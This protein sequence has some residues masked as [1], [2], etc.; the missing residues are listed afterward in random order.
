MN[1]AVAL[2]LSVFLTAFFAL[3]GFFFA[4]MRIRKIGEPVVRFTRRGGSSFAAMF[5]ISFAVMLLVSAVMIFFAF[6]R[7]FLPRG[8]LLAC[9]ALGIYTTI[10]EFYLCRFDGIYADVLIVNGKLYYRENFVDFPSLHYENADEF[11]RQRTILYLTKKDHV[12]QLIFISP[13]DC[14][15]AANILKTWI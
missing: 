3:T 1:L 6:F 8:I 5:L 11:I 4:K 2:F 12:G 10:A 15:N 9:A 13:E 7:P 14:G